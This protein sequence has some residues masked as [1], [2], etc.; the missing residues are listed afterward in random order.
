M[1]HDLLDGLTKAERPERLAIS[2]GVRVARIFLPTGDDSPAI[3]L[4]VRRN[5][6]IARRQLARLIDPRRIVS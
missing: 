1:S 4:T 5:R 6:E 2:G 3:R